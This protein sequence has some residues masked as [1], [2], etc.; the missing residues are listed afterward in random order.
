MAYIDWSDKLS[1]KISV[2]DEQH[3][4]LIEIINDLY[5][6]MQKGKGKDVLEDVF[7]RLV[8]YVKT[9]FKTEEK[10]MAEYDY[11]DRKDHETKHNDL[12]YQVGQLAIK[13]QTGKI[14]VSLETMAFLKDW[15][16]NHI[17]KTDAKLGQYL[18]DKGLH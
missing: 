3:K 14:T 7:A 2:I 9:H 17:L 16:Y 15:L 6:A 18:K 13:A 12:T 1:V 5:D 8:E 11:P 10:L 4:K